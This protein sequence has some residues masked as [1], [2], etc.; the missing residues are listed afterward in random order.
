MDANASED[1]DVPEEVRRRYT[2]SRVL[3]RSETA[4]R[5]GG[6]GVKSHEFW[7]GQKQQVTGGAGVKCHEFWAG[8][9]QQVAGGGRG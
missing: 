5:W 7:A 4:G 8:Q 6:G 3:G 2:I 9:K 1:K